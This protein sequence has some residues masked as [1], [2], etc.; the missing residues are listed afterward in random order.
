MSV[1]P[2]PQ[3]TPKIRVQTKCAKN[4]KSNFRNAQHL[5]RQKNKILA[6]NPKLS[7]TF[8][9]V[10]QE[11]IHFTL[12]ACFKGA[13]HKA[14]QQNNHSIFFANDLLHQITGGI[15]TG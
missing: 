6:K 11:V 13:Y 5:E 14:N 1:Q 2:G 7:L 4:P 9:T 8:A 10:N 12:P 3:G 15:I